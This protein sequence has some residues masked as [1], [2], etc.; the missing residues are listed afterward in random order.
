MFSNKN[1]LLKKSTVKELIIFIN[2]I[3]KLKRIPNHN[4]NN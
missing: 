3:L 1:L 4:N 2:S